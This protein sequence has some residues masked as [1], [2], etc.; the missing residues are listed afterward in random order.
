MDE[1]LKLGALELAKAIKFKELKSTEIVE[2]HIEALEASQPPLNALVE[3]RFEAAREEA[4][5]VD[6]FIATKKYNPKNCPELPPLLGV[7]FT[8]KEMIHLEGMKSTQGSIHRKENRATQD[9][10]VIKRLKNAGAIALATS[11]VA[12]VGFWFECYNS[13]YGRSNNP[14][15]EK[16]TPGGS[17]G[18]EGA[19]IGYGA[20]P[21]GIGSDVG[22]SIRIP[23]AFCGVF[24]HKPTNRVIPLTGHHPLYTETAH[25]FSAQHYPYTSLGPL[26]K[27][28]SDLPLLMSL[29]MGP[30]EIDPATQTCEELSKN[31]QYFEAFSRELSME[32]IKVL[33]LP[34]PVFHGTTR[35]TD[36]I[37]QSVLNAVKG[38]EQFG[39]ITETLDSRF[40]VSGFEIWST[41]LHQVQ[42]KPFYE[43]L[44]PEGDISFMKEFSSLISPFSKSTNYTLPSL[45]VA[46]FEK[47]GVQNKNPELI[48]NKL[49]KMKIQLREKLGKN[50]VLIL[51]THPRVAPL[52]NQS[53][54]TPFDF[55][56]TGIFNVMGFPATSVPMGL[57]EEGLPLSVQI[58]A[59]PNNDA[60]NFKIARL[61]E[62]LFGGWNPPNNL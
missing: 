17:S 51:P 34:D 1:I 10:S 33:S 47:Y 42:H 14:Y 11:N 8:V 2:K 13:V 18:G 40:F 36:E 39:A 62:K 31:L 27:K 57:S 29:M 9:A 5:T 35:A 55:I 61:L 48:L 20:S 23:A 30:D 45:L 56:Y 60:L 26:C 21:F 32:Q 59:S 16:R 52:H 37:K 49:E 28:A 41:A 44:C 58:V 15:S 24:G 19:L 4:H 50:G 22:G 54:K 25:E 7:P 46:A 6:E 43:V 3:E 38:L 53:L 12:E